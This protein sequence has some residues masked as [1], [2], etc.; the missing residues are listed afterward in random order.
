MEDDLAIGI[1]TVIDARYEVTSFLGE[2]GFA[3]VY[4]ARHLHMNREV[5]VKVLNLGSKVPRAEQFEERFRRE[6]EAAA[7]IKHPNVVTIYDY[8]VYGSSRQPYMVMDLLDGHDL[9]DEI[10]ASGPLAPPRALKL[11]L[12]VLDA[13]GLGH[14]SG[15]VHKDLKPSNLFLVKPGSASERL[16]ILD[17]G[18]ASITQGETKR[19]TATGQVLG[20]PQYLAPEYVAKQLATPALDVY[21]MALILVETMTGTA[22]CDAGNPFQC[23][24]KHCR[25]E[26]E[27][28][29]ALLTGPL[30]PALVKGLA[31]DPEERFPNAHAFRDALAGVHLPPGMAALSDEE[32]TQLRRIPP[33]SSFDLSEVDKA[34][35]D[36]VLEAEQSQDLA[37]VY[38]PS[39][40]SLNAI[41]DEDEQSAPK[42]SVLP[43]LL[44]VIIV[45]LVGALGV[46]FFMV[47]SSPTGEEAEDA[48]GAKN[49]GREQPVVVEDQ[50][51]PLPEADA[52]AALPDVPVEELASELAEPEPAPD[53]EELPTAAPDV[54]PIPAQIQLFLASE[55]SDVSVFAGDVELGRT[56]FVFTTEARDEPLT[57]RFEKR[58]Y[59][60]LEQA[61][62]IK[63]GEPINVKLKRRSS[64]GHKKP[65]PKNPDPKNPDPKNPDG[66][67][68]DVILIAP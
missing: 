62:T 66:K 61:F 2:G 20:T 34:T 22:V 54:S 3:T 51:E 65:D 53:V 48:A 1:G 60:A 23:M 15:I 58:G 41:V 38:A 47:L 42:K 64:D 50:A 21:Q 40:G 49:P 26:L 59:E 7:A 36:F 5:A 6:A 52:V 57:L 18:V 29:A 28:P 24:M 44:V 27:I 67:K 19:L 8:G 56:P 63:E 11:F 17:F 16:L 43:L 10:T 14:E 9:D 33:P 35:A 12:P 30:G 31:V 25:A 13:L 46:F 68:P 4:R 55:P 45:L 32:L 39:T 37:A